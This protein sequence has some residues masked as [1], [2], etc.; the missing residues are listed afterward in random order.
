MK[1]FIIYFSFQRLDHPEKA[2]CLQKRMD[3]APLKTHVSITSYLIYGTI[4]KYIYSIHL[5]SP[6]IKT[7]TLNILFM[8]LKKK[9]H[10]CILLTERRKKYTG[11]SDR[12]NNK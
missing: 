1:G 10:K 8:N 3:G 9:L 5:R 12:G 11:R 6:L 2:K 7:A 4:S